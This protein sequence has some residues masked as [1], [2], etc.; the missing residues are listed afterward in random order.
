MPA[1][2]TTSDLLTVTNN[3]SGYSGD[4]ISCTD[5]DECNGNNDCSVYVTCSNSDGGYKCLTPATTAFESNA[6]TLTTT[7]TPA[8]SATTLTAPALTDTLATVGNRLTLMSTSIV[9]TNAA[10]A[11]LVPTP[12]YSTI[13]IPALSVPVSKT[14]KTSTNVIPTLRTAALIL[15]ARMAWAE[16]EYTCNKRY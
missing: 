10:L 13:A 15:S 14:A 16:F 8:L 1:S 6:S 9:T 11:P 7:A 3:S 5:I 2:S 4:E 12:T